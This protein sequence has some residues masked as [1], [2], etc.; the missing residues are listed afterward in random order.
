MSTLGVLVDLVRDEGPDVVRALV[1][2]VARIRAKRGIDK[3]AV[4]ADFEA[5]GREGN[6]AFE[7]AS[8]RLHERFASERS[9]AD[10]PT[11]THRINDTGAADE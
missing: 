9:R 4:I 1:A 7:Q 6:A 11:V 3:A 8:A 5:I 10:E 2:M